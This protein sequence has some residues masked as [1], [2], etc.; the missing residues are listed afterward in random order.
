MCSMKHAFRR[1]PQSTLILALAI[2]LIAWPRFVKAASETL[3]EVEPTSTSANTGEMFEVN[4]TVVNVQNLYG[5]EIT[6][7]WNASVLRVVGIDVRLGQPDG[8]LYNPFFIAQNQ[9]DQ[10]RGRFALAATSYSQAPPF[11]GSGNIVRITFNVTDI[12]YS[13]LELA[14][15]LYDYPPLDRWPRVSLPIDHITIDGSFNVIPEFADVMVL[16]L[17]VVVASLFAVSCK[18]RSR[19]TLNN[20]AHDTSNNAY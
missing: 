20:S 12:G 11:N 17:L 2:S 5:V 19:S 15:E 4:I 6:L 1:I 10:E 18:K 3:V 14:S 9:T 16:L 8:I 7:G 13:A